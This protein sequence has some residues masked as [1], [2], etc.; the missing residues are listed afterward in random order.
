MFIMFIIM[1]SMSLLFGAAMYYENKYALPKR[2]A[3]YLAKMKV[4]NEAI[5]R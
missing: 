5:K 1:M 3:K 4:I 2:T